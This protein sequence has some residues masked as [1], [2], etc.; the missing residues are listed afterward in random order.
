[1]KRSLKTIVMMILGISLLSI[2][3]VFAPSVEAK[4]S[5]KVTV[6]TEANKKTKKSKKNTKKTVNAT[7]SLSTGITGI[8]LNQKIAGNVARNYNIKKAL[9]KQKKDEEERLKKLGEEVVEY[10]KKF[11]GN[12]YRYGG[13]SLTHGTDC[14][15]FTY[16]VYKHFGYNI[17]RPGS[18]QRANLTKISLDDIRPGDLIFYP[19]HVAI[20]AGGD[21]IVHA[22]T[23][24]HG[25]KVGNMYYSKPTCARR[26]L[27]EEN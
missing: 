22:S 19:G 8:D 11:V 14:S 13:T 7:G 5:S 12:P 3:A 24:K 16:S 27:V 26:V 17:D 20:Y 18:A 1:M 2:G 25:I 23:P 6:K 10:A 21:R 9:K 15:G 4:K